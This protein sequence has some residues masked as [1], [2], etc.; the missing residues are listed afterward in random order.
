MMDHGSILSSLDGAEVLSDCGAPVVATI[1]NLRKAAENPSQKETGKKGKKPDAVSAPPAPR[2]GGYDVHEMNARYALVLTDNKPLVIEE[3]PEAAVRE[4]YRFLAPEAFHAWFSNTYTETVDLKGGI[5]GQTYSSR[6]MKDGR[7]R[8][9]K[10]MC[11][12][13]N[14]DGGKA[15]EGA[16]NLWRG[17]SVEP[18]KGGKY[19]VFRDHLLTNVC[20]GNEGLFNWVF[21]FF[22]HMVQRPRERVGVA[23][24][25]RGKMGTGK[26]KVTEVFGSLIANHFFLVDDPRYVTGNFNAHMASCILLGVEEAV[27]AGDNVAEGRLKSLI[28]SNIQ[29]IEHKGIDPIPL[30]NYVRICMTSNEGWVVPAGPDERRYAV[31]D[32][33]DAVKGNHAYFAE[34]D[35]ELEKGGRE[36]LLFDLLNFDLSAVD[37]WTIPKTTALLEQKIRSFRSVHQWFLGRLEAGT[38]RR[39]SPDWETRVTR[40]ELLDDYLAESDRIGIKRRAAATELGMELRKILPGLRDERPRNG[41]G[42]RPRVY[43]LPSLDECRASFEKFVG[44]VYDWREEG[45]IQ[46]NMEGDSD[47]F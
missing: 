37:L 26:T 16:F 44:H 17:F 39:K 47:D 4:R 33:S 38:T 11:F 13:P 27:W 35:A 6:W 8:Q 41:A 30:D 2:D 18:R 3:S 15:P 20:N 45:A 22:A 31:L 32:I 43:C 10:K 25:L 23:L 21:A 40:D 7:R 28:T 1:G 14:P 9:Y 5:K 34:M 19:T 46:P 12:F 24:V 42:E 29:M 36:A